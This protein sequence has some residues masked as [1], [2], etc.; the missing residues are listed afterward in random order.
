MVTAPPP[1]LHDPPENRAW[2]LVTAFFRAKRLFEVQYEAYEATVKDIARRQGVDRG[3]LQ[4]PAREVAALLDFEQLGDLHD[5][6]VAP[7]RELSRQVLREVATTDLLDRYV[8][9]IYHEISILREEHYEVV[10]HGA[11]EPG[12]LEDLKQVLDEVHEY[13]P[14]RLHRVHHLFAQAERRLAALVARFGR[15]TV[16][17][18]SMFLLGAEALGSV[19]VQAWLYGHVYAGGAAE[20]DLVAAR[21]FL[22]G[23]FLDLARTAVERGARLLGA[24]GS[25]TPA[26][27]GLR[28]G[29]DEVAAQLARARA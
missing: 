27:E 17:V 29:Y 14:K 12:E 26:V 11:R 28:A 6:C 15:N 8:A 13:F 3:A 23:G 7:L 1:L 4:L 19:E 2:D 20:G 16:F 5:R 9:D 25:V 21:S 24:A 10:A 22:A 18:R